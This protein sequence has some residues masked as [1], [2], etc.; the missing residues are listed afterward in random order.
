[1]DVWFSTRKRFLTLRADRRPRTSDLQDGINHSGRHHGLQ[2]FMNLG[3]NGPEI[4]TLGPPSTSDH[5]SRSRRHLRVFD[6]EPIGVRARHGQL[7]RM[8]CNV[9]IC[10]RHLLFLDVRRRRHRDLG[11]AEV[12]L[13]GLH[14]M[15]ILRL[16]MFWVC[17]D[18]FPRSGIFLRN[19][20]I[21]PLMLVLKGYVLSLLLVIVVKG[22]H[23]V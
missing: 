1:M 21:A 16:I 12:V 18:L 17:G 2:T 22:S 15:Q 9:S 3:Q 20:A 6:V 19:G 14:G 13:H 4:V 8:C 11:R 10:W 7:E 23:Q 5:P